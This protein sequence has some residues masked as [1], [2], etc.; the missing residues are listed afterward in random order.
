LQKILESPDMS[1]IAWAFQRLQGYSG[2]SPELQKAVTRFI[3][4]ENYSLASM[5]IAS[6]NPEDLAS[7]PLQRILLEKLPGLNYSL[8]N[9][10]IAKLK[11]A[12]GLDDSVKT[13]LANSLAAAEGS[14]M[15]NI[16]ELFA[17]QNITDAETCRLVSGLLEHEN[18][19]AARKAFEFLEKADSRDETV[20]ERMARYKERQEP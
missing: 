15:I 7:A 10:I 13:A 3:K 11:E 5:A 9:R 16:L 2:L 1:D 19:F 18:S 4:N 12:P 14:F 20:L 8:K 6:V 17:K